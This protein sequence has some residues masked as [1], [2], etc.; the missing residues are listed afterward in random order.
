MRLKR[1]SSFIAFKL[2][3]FMYVCIIGKLFLRF[4]IIKMN[5]PMRL[6]IIII[7]DS[8]VIITSSILYLTFIFFFF[9]EI[10]SRQ[11]W[12]FFWILKIEEQS[13]TSYTWDIFIYLLQLSLNRGESLFAIKFRY[14]LYK[15]GNLWFFFVIGQSLN[16]P[17]LGWF[18]FNFNFFEI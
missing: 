12:I 9:I 2:P 11:N 4:N 15:Y 7:T 18:L 14:V 16:Y 13:G 8:K 1:F 6:I 10:M 3:S 5:P 17:N